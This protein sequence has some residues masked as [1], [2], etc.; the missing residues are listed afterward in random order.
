VG[1]S[2][3]YPYMPLLLRLKRTT[4]L[5]WGTIRGPLAAWPRYPGE[6]VEMEQA[7]LGYDA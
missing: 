1:E 7:A 3:Q 4:L 6:N 2:P 5:T